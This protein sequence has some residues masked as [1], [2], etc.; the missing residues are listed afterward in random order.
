[1]K[2]Y[3][4]PIF[5]LLFFAAFL[6]TGFAQEGRGGYQSIFLLGAGARQLG[7]GG[8]SVAFPQDATTIYWNPAGMEELQRKSFTA[9]YAS[10]MLG[11][12][13]N[14]FGYVHPTL[15]FGTFGVG[16][17]RISTGDIPYRENHYLDLGT[18]NYDQEEFYFSYAKNIRDWFTGGA[19][20]KIERQVIGQYS[21]IGFGID[22]AAFY[23]FD[24]D[25]EW[26]KNTQVGVIY[27][28]VYAPRLRLRQSVDYMPSMLRFGVAKIFYFSNTASP[29]VVLMDIQKG[30]REPV[31]FHLGTEYNYNGQ[32]MLRVGVNDRGLTFGAGAVYKRYE[33]DYS[34][35]K[36]D[37]R[38]VFS[39]SHRISFVV[40]FGKSRVEKLQ[41]IEAKRQKE[42]EERIA[43]EN[44]R[45][46][47]AQIKKL[48]GEGKDLYASDDYFKAL[49][50]F[51]QVLELDQSNPEA[52]DMVDETRAR[53]TEIRKKEMD[54][55][56]SKIQE[57][58]QRK[59]IQK[60]V[61]KHVNRGLDY[62][63]KGDYGSA[64]NEWNL[65]L[66]R[67]PDSQ[68]IKQY[69]EDAKNELMSKITELI[70][71]ADKLAKKGNFGEANKL[72][73]QALLLSQ[74]DEVRQEKIRKR[75]AELEI[76]LNLYDYYQSGL[77]AYRSENWKEA[78]LNF[79]KALKLNPRDPK[80]QGYYKDA[81]R[82]VLAR[83]QQMTPE[84]LKKF[85]KGLQLYVDDRI[86]DAI[87]VWEDLLKKQP[88][89]KQIIESI[90]MAKKQLQ[91]RRK[92][93]K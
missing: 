72:Y 22:L 65:A 73:N 28:N 93:R 80:I 4:T 86:E 64:I 82:H 87:Q 31:K 53:M 9:F 34:Y 49:V 56:L 69:I 81:E 89:N 90:D 11:T 20:I 70:D 77:I 43:R 15:S 41:L 24:F 21:D 32:A 59:Q 42:I 57:T 61:D 5:L 88:Y 71:R 10:L 62:L 2:K 52:L 12:S 60:F 78:M 37:S 44:E 33:L 51:Q 58:R 7:M 48:L 3:F 55:Q 84:M 35:G 79:E 19:N 46:R 54:Q 8:A 25:S 74:D 47:R 13:Y 6:N 18:F 63:K 50:K 1:M 45:R 76:K 68:Q 75:M 39:G 29:F 66:D 85:N 30:D 38:N 91:E 36:I 40:N 17:S 26:L 23:K 27:Q 92:A 67:Q 16:V 83:K 14:Y